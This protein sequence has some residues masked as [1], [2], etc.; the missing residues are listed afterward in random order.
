MELLKIQQKNNIRYDAEGDVLYFGI[1]SGKEEEAIEIAPGIN[2]EV[3][4]KGNV[5]GIEVLRASR[6]LK[7]IARSLESKVFA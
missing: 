7:P 1:E 4:K 2:V 3:N 6:A 5:I